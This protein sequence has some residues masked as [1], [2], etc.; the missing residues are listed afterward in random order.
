MKGQ[1][2][3]ILSTDPKNYSRDLIFEWLAIYSVPQVGGRTAARR[4]LITSVR[5]SVR[6]GW[7][8]VLEHSGQIPDPVFCPCRYE[9]V[10]ET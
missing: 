8:M 4:I 5:V 3:T 6:L 10:I 1:Y 2:Q 9:L 7:S